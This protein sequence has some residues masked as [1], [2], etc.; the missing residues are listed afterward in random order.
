MLERGNCRY[1]ADFKW[2]KLKRTKEE[3]EGEEEE[4][5]YHSHICHLLTSESRFSIA[6][7]FTLNEASL[8]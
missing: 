5:Y 2:T 3:V 8:S 4:D 1:K 7:H 6:G